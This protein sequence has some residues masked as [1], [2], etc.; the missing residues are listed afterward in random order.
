MVV[1]TRHPAL[2]R[3][4]TLRVILGYTAKFKI[5][6]GYKGP[7]CLLTPPKKINPLLSKLTTPRRKQCFQENKNINQ[8]TAGKVQY[9][10]STE[11]PRHVL[12]TKRR[13]GN[14]TKKYV[15]YP[16]AREDPAVGGS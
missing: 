14:V 3:D 13:Q 6:L 5:S 7:C 1:H 4:R 2:G 10:E 9:Q 15:N 16:C 12:P 8:L 11:T